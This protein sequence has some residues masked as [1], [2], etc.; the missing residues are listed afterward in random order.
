MNL[1][2]LILGGSVITLL[3][4]HSAHSQGVLTE[5]A[6]LPA[7][8]GVLSNVVELRDGRLAFADTRNKLFLRA[9]LEH[10]KV[11]P[12]G[13]SADSLPKNAPPSQ[14][15]FPGWVAHLAG[16]TVA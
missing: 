16:D 2:Y 14:Y 5:E 8:L 15:K 10:K 4:C 3:A 9:D 7:R 13:P 12:L 1:S 11:D 6:R